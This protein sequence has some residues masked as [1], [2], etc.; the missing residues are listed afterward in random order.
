MRKPRSIV[1]YAWLGLGVDLLLVLGVVVFVLAGAAFQR[2]AITV[3]SQRAQH[4]QLV[5]LTLRGDFLD[6]QRALRGYQA[7]GQARFLE[8][9]YSD[10][11]SFVLGLSRL[12][13]L[14]WPAVLGG[15]TAQER[16]AEAAFLDGGQAVVA[17]PGTRAAAG[18]YERAS[19]ASDT[20]VRQNQ[21]LQQR[22][23]AENALLAARA[24]RT[25]GI[26]MAGTVIVLAVG[27]L[28]PVLAFTLALRWTSAP[29]RDITA[30]VRRWARGDR[31]A[32]A[33]VTGPADARELALSLNSMADES[34]R[35]RSV[36]AAS[37]RIRER[38]EA[39]A[40]LAETMAAI[41]EH[42]DADFVWIGLVSGGELEVVES[43]YPAP[44]QVA[45]LLGRLPPETVPWLQDLY[46]ARAS[47]TIQDLRSV[48]DEEIAPG[49][50]SVLLDMGVVSL[51]LTPFGIGQE[52]LG[53]LTLMRTD[54]A[55]PW[56]RQETETVEA[57]AV[58]VA[59]GL[60]HA[61]LYDGKQHLVAQL[62]SLDRAKTDFL[63]SV[64]HDFRTP[65]TSII[66]YAEMIKDGEAGPVTPKQ[67]EMLGAVDRNVE[68]LQNL[69]EDM[70]TI[71]RIELGAFS[72]DLRPVDLAALVPTAAGAVRPS[73]VDRGLTFDV[74]APD[75]TLAVDADSEQID[76]LLT[77]LLSNAVKYTPRGGN[78]TLIADRDDGYA[79]LVVK[80]T[81]IG[82]PLE[83]QQ[84]AF[85]R[86]F[87]ASNAVRRSIPGT[88]LGLSIVG[89][90]VENHHGDIE[91]TSQEDAGTTVTVRLPLRGGRADELAGPEG[92]R[93]GVVTAGLTPQPGEGGL[94]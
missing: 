42:L 14:A 32:R 64:T 89:S 82:I 1:F 19:A 43:P 69:I 7:T 70:L 20:F 51:L 38:L 86:F 27:L 91:L 24:E 11:A 41:E 90:I 13:Q 10:Q 54:P 39:P 59:R 6:T 44:E 72:S 37:M 58:D 9:F 30:T 73:A 52:M 12:R 49:I 16:Y 33:V 81:G 31:A 60:E 62:Q 87:R 34:D 71:S 76:R 63:A 26:G 66:G 28:L 5:N 57:L 8:T 17:P 61:R 93:P 45:G 18:L 3:L 56:T 36:R 77:N 46:R 68:R 78:V 92:G 35:L 21:R 48:R 88:G 23:T 4:M 74:I 75:E 29:L 79:R 80:D 40:V 47:Y 22:L 50:R 2:S 53:D 15:V 55:K 84:S 94:R 25:L 85:G 83:E 67:T 65:L